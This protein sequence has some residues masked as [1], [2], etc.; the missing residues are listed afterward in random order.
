MDKHLRLDET[1]AGSLYSLLLPLD[2]F[3]DLLIFS[4]ASNVSFVAKI[5]G[6]TE[7]DCETQVDKTSNID[8]N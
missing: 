3:F 2:G 4:F 5:A 6:K 8:C 1:S 7:A